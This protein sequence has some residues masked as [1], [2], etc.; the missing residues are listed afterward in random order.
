MKIKS[1]AFRHCL[2]IL[3][4]WLFY[5]CSEKSNTD[6][7]VFE[8][9]YFSFEIPEM[10]G[11]LKRRNDAL[12][13]EGI[14]YSAK[15]KS[16]AV[17]KIEVS[18]TLNGKVYDNHIKFWQVNDDMEYIRSKYCDELS[19]YKVM[20][21]SEYD[22]EDGV[23]YKSEMLFERTD[24]LKE[25]G[26]FVYYRTLFTKD[27]VLELKILN[28]YEEFDFYRSIE[29]FMKNKEIKLSLK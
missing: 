9:E 19:P 13:K 11:E 7:I 25:Y 28:K 14:T 29:L 17:E 1:S 12:Q 2:F 15:I 21:H 22:Y 4:L 5:G 20:I 6:S 18:Y 16:E 26:N 24:T 3:L 23:W 8:T 27:Q 10:Q